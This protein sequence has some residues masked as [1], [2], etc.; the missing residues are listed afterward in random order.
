MADGYSQ[1][2]EACR[3]AAGPVAF[4]RS[5]DPVLICDEQRRFV[6]ANAASCLFLRMARDVVLGYRIDDL[7][8]PEMLAHVSATWPTAAR[9]QRDPPQ[10]DVLS[11]ELCLPDGSSVA[12]RLSTARIAPDEHLVVIDLP[13]VHGPSDRAR[14]LSEAERAVLALVASGKTERD[15]GSQLSLSPASVQAHVNHALLRLNAKNRAH[16]IAVAMWANEV[17]LPE[18][19]EGLA[20]ATPAGEPGSR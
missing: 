10:L 20:R 5:L 11:R 15:I 13:G 17:E 12:A 1:Q 18:G 8:P 4:E 9:Q 3:H 14:R 6:D 16:G 2:R 19:W 7:L